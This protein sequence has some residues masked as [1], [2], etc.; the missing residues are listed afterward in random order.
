RLCHGIRDRDYD[1]MSAAEIAGVLP[2]MFVDSGDAF[3]LTMAAFDGVFAAMRP[4][5]EFCKELFGPSQGE[6]LAGELVGGFANYTSGSELGIWRLA[7][8]AERAPA[9]R[10][11][12]LRDPAASTPA[13]LRAVDG[14]A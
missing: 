13:A 1:A 2:A 11:A 7:R 10:D 4:F 8:L 9:L 6:A 12:I 14:G 5:S 3:G